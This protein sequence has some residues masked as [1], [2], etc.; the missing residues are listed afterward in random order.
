MAKIIM[1]FFNGIKDANNPDAMPIFYESFLQGLFDTGND[2]FVLSHPF[3][4]RDFGDIE[5]E[6]KQ[7]IQ[8]FEPDVCFIFNNSFYDLSDVVECP[9]IIYE[10]DSPTYY[11]NKEVLIRKPERF[12]YFVASTGSIDIIHSAYGVP[13]EKIFYVPFFT[14]VHA[15]D[16][17]QTTNISFVGSKFVPHPKMLPNVFTASNPSKEEKELFINFIEQI[18]RNPQISLENSRNSLGTAASKVGVPDILMYLSVEKRIHVLSAVVDLG[19]E[20]YGT[21]NWAQ[22]YYYDYRL[23]LA[24]NNKKVYSLEH[25]QNIY[26]SSKIGI[27]VAH[28]QATNGFPWRVMDIMA[29][30]ACLVTDYHSDFERLFPG[31]ELPTY[32]SEY[33]AR[34]I[35]KKLLVDE[36]RRREIVLQCQDIIDKKYRFR[37]LLKQMEECCGVKMHEDN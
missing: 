14:E 11:S 19:L 17:P 7:Q 32:E 35:C 22:D 4:G 5:P 12:L 21:E 28:I 33:E 20:L 24:Y 34:E 31:I 15:D 23:N 1:A 37:H 36:S 18:K 27:S 9:I 29:S 8:D 16:T 30:N 3:W 2:V 13:K 26:N 10:V 25:N 6:L